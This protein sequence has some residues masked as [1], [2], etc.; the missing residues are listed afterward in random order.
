[1]LLTGDV[2]GTILHDANANGAKDLEEE[3]LAGWTV[4]LDLNDSGGLDEG[5]PAQVTNVDGDYLLTGVADGTYTIREVLQDGWAPSPGTADH[6]ALAVVD[7]DES[8]VNF[9]NYVPQI[10]DITGTV[11][12]D[13]NGDGIRS[14]GDSG[15]AG[16]TIFLDLNND[17]L[18]DATEPTRITDANG[19]Y[20]FLDLQ[21]GEYKVREVLQAGWETP[22]GYDANQT[23][24]VT[25][26]NTSVA[27]FANF[28]PE[29]GSVSGTV[30]NDLDGDGVRATDPVTGAYT[31]P[32]LA[33][34]QIFADLNSDGS[35]TVGEPAAPSGADGAYTIYA[36]PYGV[37]TIREVANPDFTPTAPTT[38]ARSLYLLN[39]ESVDGYD[40]GNHERS[41]ASISGTVFADSDHDGVRDSGER[42]L[43]GITVYLDLDNDDLLDDGEPHVVTS[44]DLYYTPSVDEAGS[45]S[46]THLARGTYSIREIVPDDQSSTPEVEREHSVTVGPSDDVNGVNSGNV[47]RPNEIH[48]V[49]FDDANGNHLKDDG[50]LGG[51]G[52][53]IFI[54]ADRDNLFDDGEPSTVTG[55]DGS[56]VF[57]DLTPGAYVVREL[58]PSGYEVTFP[59]TR[60][61]IL[62]PAGVS[63][64]A[65]GN[66]SP[67]SITISLA[68]GETHRETVSLTLPNAGALTNLVDVFLLF[69]DTGS[70]TANSPIVRAAFPEIIASLQTALPG[71]N[72]GFGVGRLEEYANFAAEYASG[73]PFILNHP[74]VASSTPGFSTA[75]QA[76]LDRMAPGYGGDQ[77]ETVFEALYQVVTGAGFDGNNNGSTLDS[78][79]AGLVAT[80]L[81]P[82]SSGDVPPFAS[83]TM[84]A[85]G[86]VLPAEG[87]LGG[88]GFRT[89]ALPI[90]LTATDTGFAYQPRGETTITGVGGLTIPVS[91]LTQT[92]RPTTPFNAG[93][94]IQVTITGLNALG[95]LVI[96]LG[97]NAEPNIDPRQGLEAI[98]RL[99]GATNQSAAT[100]DNG[101]PDA[102]APGDPFYFQIASGFAASVANGVVAAIQNAVTNVAVN[103][104]IRASD[105]RVQIV[106]HTGTIANVG[107]GDT[108]TFDIEFLGNGIPRR[109]DLQFVREG[110]NVVLGSIPVVLGTPI[111]GDGYEFEE[112]DDGEY[113][114]EVDFG[115]HAIEVVTPNAAPSFIKGADQSILEDAGAQTVLNWATT[116][117]AG[118]ASEASQVVD[119]TVSNDNNSL[120]TVQP[121]IS[122]DGTLSFSPAPDAHG[123]AIVTVQIHDDGGMAN[124]GIDASDPQTFVITID[125]VNDAPIAVDEGFTTS[126]DQTLTVA[127]RGVLSNDSDMDGDVLAAILVAGPAHGT[128]TL[129][130]DGSF[131]YSPAANFNG[132]DSFSYTVN[133]GTTDSN[134]AI[135]TLA[136]DAVNDAP[137]AAS[138]SYEVDQ[139]TPLIV[140]LATGVLANDSDVDGDALNAVLITEPRHGSITLNDDGSFKYVPAP[141]YFGA[142]SFAYTASDGS[143][144]SDPITVSIDVRQVLPPGPKFTV[145]DG[146]ARGAFK[147]DAAGQFVERQNLNLQDRSP[148]GVAANKDGTLFWIVDAKRQ[149]FVHDAAGRLL[150]SWRFSG[151]IKPEGIATNGSDLWIVDHQT[152]RLVY[153]AGA[154]SLR[155]GTAAPTASFPLASGNRNPTDVTTDGL[156]FWVVDDHGR[157]DRV[158]RYT[159]NG[160]ADGSWQIDVTNSAP[161]GLTIDPNDVNHIWIVD[162]R[163]DRVFQ[164]NGAAARTSGQQSA[165]ASFALNSANGNP[166]G[167]ADPLHRGAASARTDATAAVLAEARSTEHVR[168]SSPMNRDRHHAEHRRSVRPSHVHDS[169]ELLTMS[170]LAS[171]DAKSNAHDQAISELMRE[172]GEESL[173]RR[174]IRP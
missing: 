95:A 142:D 3:G 64:S 67:S 36:V 50:E 135:V 100:I 159:L 48:G 38:G 12:N 143:L 9:F 33:G 57:R 62:W 70:F 168:A 148:S 66:V 69:D 19:D 89:G 117:S 79:A 49:K 86:S 97:T 94:G 155:S 76:A 138:E 93:A 43:A 160:A 47:Y 21:A 80:Q 172:F 101:T 41:D 167:I 88:A 75:I 108:A 98:A 65:V 84:D 122:P 30:W 29:A 147:Y 61:G 144:T 11:W 13:F 121:T 23:V 81:N 111:P 27:D 103:L 130:S 141:S 150:G 5:E 104:T 58:V 20:S 156:R 28:T 119:F 59:T 90:I 173:N 10:G 51:A 73:R 123:T 71:I 113:G 134:V 154:A 107:A 118:P 99:T 45:Y 24:F 60:D 37:N 6:Y 166:Q 133:D 128:V 78:G 151:V 15:L 153:F 139:D 32:G 91:E 131:V 158:F 1:M 39:G 85:S 35:L 112:L 170:E 102:I 110:T 115:N 46:F 127:L 163:A 92:S 171:S 149:V 22:P 124:G 31:E 7:G 157:S 77:P 165:D 56:Y 68:G 83:Y 16:W 18:P 116:I 87:N 129:A 96:G 126:E 152:D 40:F 54:D 120:F 26:G 82:G 146:S 74:I 164:Y 55:A 169:S 125:S 132:G 114:Q 106:N 2:A 137:L 34:W 8:K 161:T 145:V 14:A 52:I 136:V 53:T 140:P 42:G 109:F 105:P 44:G 25:T 17:T 72:L 162:S 174:L 4:F 63:N